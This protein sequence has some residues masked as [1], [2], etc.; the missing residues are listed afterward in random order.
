MK[1]NCS[2]SDDI[3]ESSEVVQIDLYEVEDDMVEVLLNGDFSIS[4]E[5]GVFSVY[6]VGRNNAVTT[7][8]KTDEIQKLFDRHSAN[9]DLFKLVLTKEH[10][11][12]NAII[13]MVEANQALS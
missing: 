1:I 6:G 13:K 8:K 2:E 7:F 11:M 12:F 5:I 4:H 3:V 9:G 10:P